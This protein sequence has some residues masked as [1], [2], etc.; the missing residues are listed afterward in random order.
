[1]THGGAGG[2]AL[3]LI[4]QVLPPFLPSIPLFASHFDHE[5]IDPPFSLSSYFPPV[6]QNGKLEFLTWH[7]V[8]PIFQEG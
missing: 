6:T 2:G 1:M 5:I 7:L 3:S 4:N 8:F